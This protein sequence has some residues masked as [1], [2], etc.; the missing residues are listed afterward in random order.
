MHPLFDADTVD[1]W[2]RLHGKVDT[3]C[4]QI[5]Q[6]R[7]P[8]VV[9]LPDGTT[10]TLHAPWFRRDPDHGLVELGGGTDPDA[11]IPL[12]DAVL[13]RVHVEGLPDVTMSRAS[14]D[15]I[16]HPV[17]YIHLLWRAENAQPL[18]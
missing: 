8:A 1:R 15:I 2:L 16:D 5:Y 13:A 14:A 17:R 11:W 6:P 3:S 10:V 7:P 18:P 4:A 9:T 12:H